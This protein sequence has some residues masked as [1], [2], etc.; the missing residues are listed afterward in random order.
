M[1]GL[2]K[3]MPDIRNEYPEDTCFSTPCN[4]HT[5]KKYYD[6][7][8]KFNHQF[9]K[10]DNAANHEWLKKLPT[11]LKARREQGLTCNAWVLMQELVEY[12]HAKKQL[13]PT[14]ISP[15]ML[16][17]LRA[18][19]PLE[20]WPLVLACTGLYTTTLNESKNNKSLTQSEHNAI[21]WSQW[22]LEKE[23]ACLYNLGRSNIIGKNEFTPKVDASTSLLMDLFV[24]AQDPRDI[25]SVV[26]QLYSQNIDTISIPMPSLD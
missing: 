18:I 10:Q 6:I 21:G 7:P 5:A 17:M 24:N 20:E 14:E 19:A 9:L 12:L 2:T 22:W 16:N 4:V 3:H 23:P 11:W 26:Q 13:Y 25:L 15:A 1:H 8:A